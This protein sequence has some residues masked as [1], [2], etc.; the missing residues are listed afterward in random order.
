MPHNLPKEY[1]NKFGCHTFTK[2]ISE[3]ICTQEIAQTQIRII[4][5]IYFIWIFEYLYASLIV[6]TLKK[7]LTDIVLYINFFTRFYLMHKLD[8]DFHCSLNINNQ[9]L[10][11]GSKNFFENICIF[12][13]LQTNIRIYW[14]VPK[15]TNEYPNILELGKWPKYK[16]K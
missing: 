4:L 3:Y 8:L 9:I 13:N 15:Y 7:M 11:K 10:E 5:E 16:Y 1:P 2:R 6:V 12:R 14:V